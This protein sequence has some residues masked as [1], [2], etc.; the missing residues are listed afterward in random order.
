M[1]ALT[2]QL[3]FSHKF[4][5]IASVMPQLSFNQKNTISLLQNSPVHEQFHSFTEQLLIVIWSR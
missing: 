4:T 2:L 5:D 3:F 1:G